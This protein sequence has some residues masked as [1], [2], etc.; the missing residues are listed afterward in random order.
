MLPSQTPADTPPVVHLNVSLILHF[1]PDRVRSPLSCWPWWFSVKP[2]LLQSLT[3]EAS[4]ASE[5]T[6]V[7]EVVVDAERATEVVVV[8]KRATEEVVD[9]ERASEVDLARALEEVLGKAEGAVQ[10][11][12]YMFPSKSQSTTIRLFTT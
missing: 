2:W 7:P 5:A 12:T 4:V 9:A 11:T 6:R 10:F 3:R 1:L 8:V